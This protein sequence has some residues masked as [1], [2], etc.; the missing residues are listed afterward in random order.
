MVREARRP[1]IVQGARKFTSLII[2]PVFKRSIKIILED[3]TNKSAAKADGSFVLFC[4]CF[5]LVRKY[6][7]E[8]AV[9][10]SIM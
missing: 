10:V 9:G 2:C 7:P 1:L 5:C 6:L 3:L 8:L 4:F